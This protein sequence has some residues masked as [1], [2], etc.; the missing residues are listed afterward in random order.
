M[1][2]T[3]LYMVGVIRVLLNSGVSASEER[4]KERGYEK[5]EKKGEDGGETTGC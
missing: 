5:R 3:W 1:R 4:H 2:K